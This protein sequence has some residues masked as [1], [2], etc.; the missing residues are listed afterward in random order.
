MSA[1]A[2]LTLL[3]CVFWVLAGPFLSS[4]IEKRLEWFVLGMGLLAVSVSWSWSGSVVVEALLRPMKVCGALLAGALLFSFSHAGIRRAVRRVMERIGP[5]F[6]VGAAVALVGLAS[7]AITMAIAALALVEL[8]AAMRLEKSSEVQV[9]VLGSFSIGLGGG[10]TPIAGPAAAIAAAKLAEGPYAELVGPSYLFTLL[11]PWLVPAILS[12]GLVAG[13]FF[14]KPAPEGSREFTDDPLSLYSILLLTLRMY[15]FVA[16]L[17]LLGAG[18]LP[19]IDRVLL[20][21][22]PWALYWLNSVSAVVDNAALAA[23]EITPRMRQEQLRYLLLAL[24]LVDG[25]LITGNA[26]NLVVAHKLNITSKE[27]A[28]FGVPV[29]AVLMLFYFLSLVVH[30][31]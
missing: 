28:R 25:A 21:A 12:L 9:A 7:G 19:L 29:G 17:V 5:R 16:G 31:P 14:T 3:L 10:L 15:V 1:F 22:P 13:L 4:W 24:F 23:V 30:A 6:A 27:W 2:T 26:P 20:T 8:L 18:L 11:G